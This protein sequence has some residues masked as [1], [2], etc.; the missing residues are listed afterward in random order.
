MAAAAKYLR[1]ERYPA[2]FQ[3]FVR[4]EQ[5]ALSISSYC[6]TRAALIHI[7]DSEAPDRPYLTVS[8]AA[9][10]DFLTL[11]SRSERRSG[12]SSDVIE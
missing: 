5:E 8:P 10:A 6:A 3:G 4:L 12:H 11:A 2:H 7:R 1:L 9:W